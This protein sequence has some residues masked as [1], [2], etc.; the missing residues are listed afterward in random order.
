LW[1]E[2][3]AGG[4]QADLCNANLYNAD[5]CNADL[6]YANLCNANLYNANLYNADLS[7]ADLHY[8]DLRCAK[9][10]KPEWFTPLL[11]LYDQPGP[12]RAYKLVTEDMEGPF[13][14]GITYEI[15]KTFEVDDANTDT[16]KQCA[17]GINLATLDW[18]LTEWRE[19][20]KV[21]ICEFMADD[22]ACI[23]TATDGKFRVKRC[24]V[25]GEKDVSGLVLRQRRGVMSEESQYLMF[26]DSKFRERVLAVADLLYS[27][28]VDPETL[29]LIEAVVDGDYQKQVELND[30][31]LWEVVILRQRR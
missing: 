7:Y 23:P 2:S 21:L 4:E 29:S 14:G 22:I 3:K 27:E 5:L 13:N 11:M 18:C 24:K 17:E 31:V 19:G 16:N 6:S 15:G 25:I 26:V 20:Y 10:I 30:K 9:G 12:I 8:A 1:L 28:G